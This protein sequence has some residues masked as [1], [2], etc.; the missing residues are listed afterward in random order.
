MILAD[1]YAI[2][3]MADG[4]LLKQMVDLYGE[5]QCSIVAIVEVPAD[6]TSRYGVIGSEIEEGVRLSNMVETP[7]PEGAP[8]NLATIGRYIL[9]PNIYEII[10]NAPPGQ[11]SEI[12]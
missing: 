5:Y 1:D 12:R 6:Q 2:S 11:S 4:V 8:S 9:T 10:E 3:D 7:R